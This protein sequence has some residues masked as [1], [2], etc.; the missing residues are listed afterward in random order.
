MLW[1]WWNRNFINNGN[2]DILNNERTVAIT[3]GV[4][5]YY[6]EFTN[7]VIGMDSFGISAKKEDILKYFGYDIETLSNKV[8]E[9]VGDKDE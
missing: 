7:K 8:I 1:C 4:K 5:D 9:L 2:Y 6:Y 3:F